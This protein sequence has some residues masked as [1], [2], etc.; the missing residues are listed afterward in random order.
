MPR[1]EHAITIGRPVGDVFAVLG[2]V[3]NTARWHP[4]AIEER[5]TSEGP[6]GIGSTRHS[7]GKAYGLR[8]ENDAEVV[9]F[10]PPSALGLRSL[11]SPV[12][13]EITILLRPE[14]NGTAITWIS[15]LRPTG[16]LRLVVGATRPLHDRQTRRGLERRKAL[17]ESGML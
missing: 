13:F 6:I 17:M 8:S 12:P 1:T 9:L 16:L 15:E 14:E 10:E 3:E 4:S 11:V 2:D 5:W 7:V